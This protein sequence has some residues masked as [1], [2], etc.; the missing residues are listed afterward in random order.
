[1]ARF[2]I[3]GTCVR[4]AAIAGLAVLSPGET[5]CAGE[6]PETVIAAFAKPIAAFVILIA[7]LMVSRVPTFSGK[8]IA[9]V[10]REYVLPLLAAMALLFVLLVSFPWET[11][12]IFAA[13][14]LALIPLSVLSYYRRKRTTPSD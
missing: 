7:V 14:Y 2:A 13:V 8:N 9:R 11:L 12:A 3:Y 1:M 6:A 4:V 10:R 5:A